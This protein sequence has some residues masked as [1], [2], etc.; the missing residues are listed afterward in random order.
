MAQS[1]SVTIYG[2]LDASV[3]VSK[4]GSTSLHEMRDNA[5]R[6]GFRGTEDLGGGLRAVFGLE[7]GFGADTGAL[8][9]PA[10]RNSFVGLT[11]GLGAFAMGRLDSANPTGS[12]IYSLITRHSEFVVHDAGVT[13]VGTAVLNARNRVSN[14]L[15]YQSPALGNFVFRARYYLNGTGVAETSAGPIRAE[16]DF[17]SVDVSVSYG[18]GKGPLGLGLGY[19]KDSR[20]GGIPVNGFEDKWMAVGSY[21]F[22]AVRAWAIVGQD[23]FRAGPATRSKVGIRYVGAS[24]DLGGSKIIGN[25]STR[26]VQSDRRGELKK[27]SLAYAH[28]LSKR[29]T[30]YVILDRTDRNSNVSGDATRTISFGMQHNF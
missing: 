10:F 11:G 20:N 18:E 29:T 5:S 17:K 16:E 21:D 6:L 23:N 25:Y 4:T 9:T 13:A 1:S 30:A 7:Y 24:L 2:R 14:A 22:G 3:D 27:V 26:D 19:G 8:G 15:G 28:R 12:P